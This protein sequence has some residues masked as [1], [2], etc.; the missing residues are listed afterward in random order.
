MPNALQYEL[1][2]FLPSLP[3]PPREAKRLA[4]QTVKTALGDGKLTG[5]TAGRWT[6]HADYQVWLSPASPF[7]IV[8]LD[9]ESDNTELNNEG[10]GV[11]MTLRRTMRLQAT[12]KDARSA[13]ANC[14]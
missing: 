1:D 11:S 14:Q 9:L 2:R 5:G 8:G 7:G 4:H 6:W 10:A 12:G 3:A 13:L